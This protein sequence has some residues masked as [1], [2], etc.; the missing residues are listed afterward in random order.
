MTSRLFRS[1]A[2]FR[3]DYLRHP[4]SVKEKADDLHLMVKCSKRTSREMSSQRFRFL[5]TSGRTFSRETRRPGPKRV[6]SPGLPEP[7]PP[8]RPSSAQ[9]IRTFELLGALL[10]R[11]RGD[12]PPLI[13]C[14]PAAE[15]LLAFPRA[16]TATPVAE[17]EPGSC[18]L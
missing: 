11:A 15:G 9:Q 17:H 8:N 16:S 7:S 3:P 14:K 2:A 18:C 12:A 13:S 5:T 6:D 4:R 1:V 10:R